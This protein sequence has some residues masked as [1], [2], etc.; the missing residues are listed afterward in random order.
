MGK[1]S[2]QRFENHSKVAQFLNELGLSPDAVR[3][4]GGF[5]EGYGGLPVIF[6]FYYVEDDIGKDGVATE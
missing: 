2:A 4:V 5:P 1:W 3:I 6:V